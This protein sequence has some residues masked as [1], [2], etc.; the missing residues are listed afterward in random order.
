MKRFNVILTVVAALLSNCVYASTLEREDVRTF[1][2][3]MSEKHGFA[4]DEL[5]GIFQEV[6]FSDSIIEAISR[7]AETLPWFRYRQIFLKQDRIEQGVQFWRENELTLRGVEE[8][9]GVPAELVV[10][11][12]GVETRY[13]K[14]KGRYNVIDS[15]STLA[16]DY[17]KRSKFF[18]SE[19]E[20]YLL[21]T[22][23]QGFN[24]LALKGSYAGAMGIP[25]FISSSYRTYAVDFNEDGV[26]DIWDDMEDAIGSVGNYFEKHGWNKGGTVAVPARV[27]GSEHEHLV[28]GELNLQHTV[29]ELM[30]YGVTTDIKLLPDTSAKLLV[31]E[32]MD[33]NEYWM[34]FENFYVITRYNHSI[35]YAM[36]VFQLAEAIRSDYLKTGN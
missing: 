4:P 2:D 27:N 17:P 1:I 33:D 30:K 13:G 14:L 28:T 25:Q 31:L 32:N 34:G 23:E 15:L 16:F 24:P 20:H 3:E 35:L 26:I 29:G 10:A 22:R 8:K 18:R 6:V 5:T 21:M 11:I 9:F 12:I 7:P 19:L 36:A